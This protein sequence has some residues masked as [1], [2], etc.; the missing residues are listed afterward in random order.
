LTNPNDAAPVYG[1]IAKSTPED[2]V[3]G[4]ARDFRS[5]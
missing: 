4:P 5:V 1:M 2:H 3:A